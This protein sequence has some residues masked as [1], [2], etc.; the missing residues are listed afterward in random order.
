LII[1]YKSAVQKYAEVTKAGSELL[2]RS[3][4]E[5][6]FLIRLYRFDPRGILPVRKSTMGG[7]TYSPEMVL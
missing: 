2:A 7:V 6:I 5:R 4:A 1:D 3:E